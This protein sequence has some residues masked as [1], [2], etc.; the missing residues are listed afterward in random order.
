VAT[1]AAPALH[2]GGRA[3]RSRSSLAW[4]A[5]GSSG[6]AIAGLIWIVG[7]G[8]GIFGLSGD[9]VDIFLPAG[10]AMLAGSNPYAVGVTPTDAPFLYAP[11][12]AT[13]YGLLA[14]AGPA[15]VHA[16]LIAAELLALRYIAGSWIRAGAFCWFPLVPWEIAAGQ[17]NLLAAAAIVAA[18]RGRPEAAAIMGMA[19][20]S[21]VL[22][23]HPR[24]WRPF[25]I[26]AA[27]FAALSLPDPMAWVWWAQRLVTTLGTPVGPL[28]PIPFL[29]RLPIGL[30]LVAW[31]RS[32]S[33]ALGAAIAMPGLYWGA[34]VIFVAPLGVAGTRGTG[35]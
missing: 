8:A 31:G 30:A 35:S 3:Q 23:V 7:W 1:G 29:L 20:V 16:V 19:K 27:I 26:T 14:P 32:W 33:R 34:L 13:I 2:D 6:W 17:M 24:D 22:A 9:V 5:L 11:P 28:V 21:P 4:F 15:A 18:I 10:R 12:W 25:L